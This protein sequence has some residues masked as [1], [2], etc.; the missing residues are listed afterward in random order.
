MERLNSEL[1]NC[2]IINVTRL[3]RMFLI[4]ADWMITA[5]T[6]YCDAVDDE[7]T[8]MVRKDMSVNCT[9][10]R[11]Y[12]QHNKDISK[13]LR[14]KGKRLNR[15]LECEGLECHR[16]TQYRDKLFAEESGEGKRNAS[17]K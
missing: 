10:Y 2:N 11:K 8:V 6:I 1:N 16:V 17:G 4:M 13:L 5:T 15:K 14:K 9:G 3:R 7:V 12:H